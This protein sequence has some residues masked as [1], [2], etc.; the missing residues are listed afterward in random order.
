MLVQSFTSAISLP[1]QFPTPTHPFMPLPQMMG[2]QRWAQ[3]SA[4]QQPYSGAWGGQKGQSGKRDGRSNVGCNFIKLVN[5][6]NIEFQQ[7]NRRSDTRQQESKL[8]PDSMTEAKITQPE[9]TEGGTFPFTPRVGTSDSFLGEGD[10][11]M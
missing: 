8:K 2:Q 4:A 5:M 1:V 11:P 9:N 3:H 6:V 10:D 7:E